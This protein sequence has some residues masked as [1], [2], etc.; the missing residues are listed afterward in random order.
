MQS[1]EKQ[2]IRSFVRIGKEMMIRYRALPSSERVNITSSEAKTKN[3]SVVGICFQSPSELPVDE[4][5][6]IE[7]R[8][9]SHRNPITPIARVAWCRPGGD[10]YTI[11][12]ELMW[13]DWQADEQLIFANYI[14]DVH[15][16]ETD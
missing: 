11:G 12:L 7:L 1:T 16:D 10:G 4:Q 2:S 14:H 9:P 15:G 13:L 8:L 6:V 3:V 5:L